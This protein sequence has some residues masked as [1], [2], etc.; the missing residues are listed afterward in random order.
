MCLTLTFHFFV[1]L[2][3][4]SLF[5]EESFNSNLLSCLYEQDA[6]ARQADRKRDSEQMSAG[7]TDNPPTTAASSANEATEETATGTFILPWW[8]LNMACT[9][10]C[11]RAHA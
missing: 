7:S 10:K 8:Q 6:A 11:Y 4:I 3:R 5:V 2:F 1:F 9:V